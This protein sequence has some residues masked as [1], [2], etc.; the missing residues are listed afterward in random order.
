M[1]AERYRRQLTI[2]DMRSPQTLRLGRAGDARAVL[3]L[4]SHDSGINL[5]AALQVRLINP[6]AQLV[7]RTKAAAAWNVSCS[8]ACQGWPRWTP[9]C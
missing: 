2:G 3:L 1:L 7:V 8:S 5:E 9:A 6:R 4:L